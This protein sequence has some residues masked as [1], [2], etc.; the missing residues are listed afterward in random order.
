MG[1]CHQKRTAHM[2][3]DHPTDD[4]TPTSPELLTRVF[5][6]LANTRRRQALRYVRRHRSLSLATLADGVAERE[7]DLPLQKIDPEV[8]TQVYL[9]LYHTHIPELEAADIV[10]YEQ[11]RDWVTARD[12]RSS[13]V[14]FSLL[15]SIPH[16]LGE[17][18][19]YG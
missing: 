3:T 18:S 1:C 16:R 15:E 8:V 6:V 12:S 9:S 13:R 5:S 4:G 10:A 14:V 19:A 2:T 17:G 7:A 11:E